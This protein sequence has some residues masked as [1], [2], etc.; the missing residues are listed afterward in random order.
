MTK[1]KK[2]PL[3]QQKWRTIPWETQEKSYS[4]EII[5]LLLSMGGLLE[6]LDNIRACRLPDEVA[7]LREKALQECL[8]A[9]HEL[10][11]W[12]AEMGNELELYDIDVAEGALPIPRNDKDLAQ[13]HLTNVYWCVCILLYS[14]AEFLLPMVA[15][16]TTSSQAGD[17]TT[18]DTHGQTPD[19]SGWSAAGGETGTPTS[20]G[21]GGTSASPADVASRAAFLGHRPRTYARKVAHSVHLFWEAGIG[22]F[23]NQI[24]LFP[25]GL[26]LRYY[27]ASEDLEKCDEFWLM[28]KLFYRPFLGTFVGRFLVDLQKDDGD[29]SKGPPQAGILVAQ[30]RA[31]EWFYGKEQQS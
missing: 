25:L 29:D 12:R 27:M 14:T 9:H 5:D 13:L 18:T 11:A 19:D 30:E 3:C 7:A 6:Q 21:L 24:S 31:R 22:A 10:Q 26:A 1:R 15:G 2:S 4:D 28:C 23:G 20:S 8:K 17:S 16:S